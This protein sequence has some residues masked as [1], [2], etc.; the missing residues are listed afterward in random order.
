V[1]RR[2]SNGLEI[3][4]DDAGYLDAVA[5]TLSAVQAR[6][7][8][9]RLLVREI[10]RAI[11]NLQGFIA[12]T[13]VESTRVRIRR[14][15]NVDQFAADP[16]NVV[17]ATAVG[18]ALGGG[19]TG[20]GNGSA[21]VIPYDPSFLPSGGPNVIRSREASIVH[22]LLHA[23]RQ[24]Q[25]LMRRRRIGE[26]FDYEEE[27]LSIVLVE[28]PFRSGLGWP[29]RRNHRGFE[30]MTPPRL[31]FDELNYR[32]LFERFERQMGAFAEELASLDSAAFPY[33][34][35]RE[36]LTAVGRLPL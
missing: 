35:Y 34:P 16:Q 7:R 21:V 19:L 33:N 11:T 1:I 2:Y 29:L 12:R 24:K 26:D 32:Y 4:G 30:E 3:E 20:T 27:F 15:Q 10:D 17:S 23:L 8:L 9:G 36:Y 13:D 5:A 22:E 18:V 31:F 28:N 25:G 6:S 14:A